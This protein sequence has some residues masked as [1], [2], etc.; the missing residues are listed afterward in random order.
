M[1]LQEAGGR[2]EHLVALYH[3]IGRRTI[4]PKSCEF[5]FF[6]LVDERLRHDA[7]VQPT[8]EATLK[9][10]LSSGKIEFQAFRHAKK[11]MTD[12]GFSV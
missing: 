4:V 11:G 2:Y 8:L 6:L 12:Q 5:Q 7:P 9:K 3:A 1:A 10:A